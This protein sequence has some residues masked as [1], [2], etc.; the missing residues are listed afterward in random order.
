M[1]KRQELILKELEPDT[2]ALGWWGG[3]LKFPGRTGA[4]AV[5]VAQRLFPPVLPCLGPEL[6]D[7]SDYWLQLGPEGSH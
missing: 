2:F 1:L 7:Q 5:G 3:G 4:A 6:G